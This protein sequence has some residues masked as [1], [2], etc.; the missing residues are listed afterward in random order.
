MRYQRTFPV[1]SRYNKMI[2]FLQNPTKTRKVMLGIILAVVIVSMVAYLGQAFTS[3]SPTST[4]TYATVDGQPVSTQE[5]SQ[6]AQ[7]M[8]RQQ[9]QGRQV[10][11]FLMP[12]LQRRAA[13]Q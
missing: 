5:V 2:K 3:T 10:P 6:T 12:Y 13:D 11:E 1:R 7:R 8:A 4:G 9:F